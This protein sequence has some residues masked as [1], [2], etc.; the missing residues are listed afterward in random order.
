MKKNETK[1][2][3]EVLAEM[4]NSNENPVVA[5]VQ[6]VVTDTT[7]STEAEKAPEVTTEEEEAEK[8]AEKSA[9]RPKKKAKKQTAESLQAEIERKTAELQAC[10]AELERKKM[11]SSH[12]TQFLK[13]LDSLEEAERKI[14]EEDDFN[15]A[16]FKLKFSDASTYNGT[17]IFTISNRF[18]LL[19]FI[20]F[21][22]GRIGKKISELEKQ[23]ING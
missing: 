23:L 6:N 5:A 21:M 18:I 19:E 16:L 11:L 7:P 15:S 20:T 13:A 3:S 10:L 17:E 4:A 2:V 12:R 1:K 9:D 22:R 14:N 8:P